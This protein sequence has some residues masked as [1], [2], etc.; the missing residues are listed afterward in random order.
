MKSFH[1]ALI[2]STLVLS[3]CS[4]VGKSYSQLN[5]ADA[6]RDLQ[7]N[8]GHDALKTTVP[9][10]TKIVMRPEGISVPVQFSLSASASD[11]KDFPAPE[12]ARYGGQGI[13]Y[14]W[15]AKMTSGNTPGFIEKRLTPSQPVQVRAFINWTGSVSTSQVT[16]LTKHKCGPL[17]QRFTPKE[18]RNYLARAMYEEDVCRLSIFDATDPSAPILTE[19]E[20]IA[21]PA[22]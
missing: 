1:C 4:T 3:G 15:I 22:P 5:P 16:H 21:C 10:G 12:I 20:T 8:N 18:G 19:S 13:V 2:L 7:R 14:P 9:G 11:C 17:V 6:Q